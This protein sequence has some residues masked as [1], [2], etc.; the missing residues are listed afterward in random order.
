MMK[1]WQEI[2]GLEGMYVINK[3]GDIKRLDHI[4]LD[5]IDRKW[6]REERIE[7]QWITKNG[8]KRV[9]LNGQH[10]YVHRLVAKTFIKRD[11]PDLVVNHID[12][13]KQNN[14]VNNLEWVTQL[15]NAQHASEANLINR[16]SVIRKKQAP[17]NARV[18]GRFYKIPIKHFDRDGTFLGRYEDLHHAHDV[19]KYSKKS[20]RRSMKNETKTLRDGTYFEI[21]D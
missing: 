11:S 8:Y 14:C 7:N 15:E 3:L 6:H 2:P 12:G 9:Y 18:G 20:I 1:K 10:Y 5:K 17:I 13:D 16:D 21:C 19:L 4:W